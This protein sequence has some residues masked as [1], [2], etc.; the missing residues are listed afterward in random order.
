M[1]STFLEGLSLSLLRVTDIQDIQVL[2]LEREEASDR[3]DFFESF[4]DADKRE[5]D[6]LRLRL[7]FLGFFTIP[8][9]K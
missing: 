6:L 4:E 9:T 2:T 3:R 5:I 8:T 7:S 1:V